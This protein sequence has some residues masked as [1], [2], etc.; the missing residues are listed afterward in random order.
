MNLVRRYYDFK[1]PDLSPFVDKKEQK[2]NDTNISLV[3]IQNCL[4]FGFVTKFPFYYA[5]QLEDKTR[6]SALVN[7]NTC[8]NK[9]MTS[10]KRN[11]K[12]KQFFK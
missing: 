1:I 9:K 2:Q 7:I 8:Y 12:K 3:S 6:I 11:K 4:L 5:Y 10:Y